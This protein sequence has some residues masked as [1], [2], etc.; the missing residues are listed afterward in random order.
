M[1]N[2]LL[3]NPEKLWEFSAQKTK[4]IIGHFKIWP[5]ASGLAS[6]GRAKRKQSR[7]Q[8]AAVG[9][10]I[11]AYTKKMIFIL[12]FF[13]S[14]QESWREASRW[15]ANGMWTPLRLKGHHDY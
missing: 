8:L 10:P 2:D 4:Q 13:Q 12:P 14:I 11:L 15:T 3:K 7:F 1:Q 6:A 9:R 5:L